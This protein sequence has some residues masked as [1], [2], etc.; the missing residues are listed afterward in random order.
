MTVDGCNDCNG[1]GFVLAEYESG[2]ASTLLPIPHA[3]C[4]TCNGEGEV[5]RENSNDITKPN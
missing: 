3:I 4:E 5:V 2:D 1:R